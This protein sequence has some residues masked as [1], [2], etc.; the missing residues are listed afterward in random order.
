[1]ALAVDDAFRGKGLGT[2]LLE[3]LAV[4]ATG[5]GFTHFWAVADPDNPPGLV[6]RRARTVPFERKWEGWAEALL[7][8]GGRAPSPPPTAARPSAGP[9]PKPIGAT[10]TGN[11]AAAC[12]LCPAGGPPEALRPVGRVQR[13]GVGEVAYRRPPR[14]RSRAGPRPVPACG[15]RPSSSGS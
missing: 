12:V 5:R 10:P 2:L 15:F 9:D 7:A 1:V 11:P 3:R 14:P 8:Q 4:L 13:P 6:G